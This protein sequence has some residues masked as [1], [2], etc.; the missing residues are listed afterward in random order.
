MTGRRRVKEKLQVFIQAAHERQEPLD[1]VLL[2]GPPGLGEDDAG[3]DHRPGDGRQHP[4]T[5]GPAIERQGDLVA[6][7]QPGARGRFVH[8]RDPPPEQGGGGSAVPGDGRLCCRYRHRERALARSF[9]P[10][11][12]P[13]YVGGGDDEGGKVISPFRDRFGVIE[14]LDYY[15]R[16]SCSGSF[17][18]LRT[19]STCP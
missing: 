13:F 6:T 15:G 4:A 2:H 17:S 3:P 18:A 5:S 16:R 11:A 9:A 1:H 7:S 10:G 14:R 12:A 8:R 19:F